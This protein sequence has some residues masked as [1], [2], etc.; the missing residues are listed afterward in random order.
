MGFVGTFFSRNAK[1]HELVLQFGKITSRSN[2]YM[3]HT[4]EQIYLTYKNV[5]E[6]KK[7]ISEEA[8]NQAISEINKQKSIDDDFN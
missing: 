1:T 5:L 3:D 2:E 4:P 7:I 8:I 6:L